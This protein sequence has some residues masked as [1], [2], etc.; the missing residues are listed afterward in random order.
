M[1]SLPYELIPTQ[2]RA[3]PVGLIVLSVDETLEMECRE[4]FAGSHSPIYA[5]RIASGDEVSTESLSAMESRLAAAVDL[6][7]KTQKY[8]VIAYGCTSAS[9][10][11]GS[12]KVEAI[13]QSVR[14]VDLVTNPLR[15]TIA[16]AQATRVNRFALL[17][18]YV[19][20]VNAPLRAAFARAGI[21]TDIFG[22]FA[23]PVE[24]KVAR[25]SEQAILE[26]AVRLGSDSSTDAVFISCTNLRTCA[27][28]DQIR[29]AIGKP[30][31][32]SNQSLFWHIE[33][34]IFERFSSET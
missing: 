28:L 17:S 33:K 34:V 14:D 29:Q 13:V 31:F 18:P 25:I 23:E 8:P 9:A 11:I 4:A 30:V 20:E 12:N 27:I 10:V 32:S 19:Q 6:L 1:M 3:A 7:P 5:T 24:S 22:T 2:D 21:S 15:A 26:S 16:Q